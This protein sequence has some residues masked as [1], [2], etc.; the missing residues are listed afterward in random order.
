MRTRVVIIV[1]L[2]LLA[3]ARGEAQEHRESEYE[4]AMTKG[5]LAMLSESYGE[6][7]TLFEQALILKPGDKAAL[8]SLGIACARSGDSKKAK[9]LFGRVLEKDPKNSRARYEYAVILNNEGY[10]EQARQM[11]G[12]VAGEAEAQ[13]MR[14]AA[15]ELLDHLTEKQRAKTS[16]SFA[17]GVQYDS[18]VV[19]EPDD[20]VVAVG[21][22]SDLRSVLMFRAKE[23]VLAEEQLSAEA[24]YSFYQNLHLNLEDYNVQ[25]HEL[26]L[27]GKYEIARDLKAGLGYSYTLAYVGG[28]RYSSIHALKPWV[29]V[30]LF[31]ASYAQFSLGLQKKA[32][33]ASESFPDNADRSASSLA[34]GASYG[35]EF[36]KGT[37][38]VFQYGYLRDAADREWWDLTQHKVSATIRTSLSGFSLFASASFADG[39][40]GENPSTTL[41][42]RHDR[43][44][45]YTVGAF[46]DI[47]KTVRLSLSDQYTFNDSNLTDYEYTRNIIGL[48]AELRL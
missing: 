10:T 15:Q 42:A 47:T 2:V 26:S 5:T 48:F 36:A 4:V 6:A 27:A 45:D 41:P 44:T 43:R 14:N 13:D 1:F 40:Y 29:T 17:A 16:I 8:T 23:P 38:I 19:L 34:A 18:N 46:R 3:G 21:R 9:E 20:S 31:T 11:L 25:Q 12:R 28:E 22:K 30:N 24:G 32:Y 39:R 37:S 7:I 35:S 33:V